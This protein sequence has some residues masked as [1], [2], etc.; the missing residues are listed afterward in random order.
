M[1]I[2][3]TY[4]EIVLAAQLAERNGWRTLSPENLKVIELSQFLRECRRH[5]LQ[6][7]D[8]TFRNAAGVSRK[9]V[10]LVTRHPNYLGKPTNGNHLDSLIVSKFLA[11]PA[12]M[13]LEAESIREALTKLAQ[14]LSLDFFEEASSDEGQVL[15]SQHIRRER[16]RPLRRRKI[17]QII[18]EG[19]KIQCE[20]CDFNFSLVYGPRGDG[21]IE[22]HH[23]IP[24]YVS[25]R[26]TTKLADLAL[27]CSN[28]HRMLHK[29]PWVTPGELRTIIE[30]RQPD[31]GEAPSS[32]I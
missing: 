4:E 20:V 22:V 23:V 2:D 17:Q 15:L 19:R 8:P 28:C 7:R 16:S 11:N 29:Q 18:S 24:L 6:S 5:P 10:D 32:A 31:I 30:S 9:T 3:W 25:G 13:I 21:Y 26:V 12:Q 27:L 1:R 14:P